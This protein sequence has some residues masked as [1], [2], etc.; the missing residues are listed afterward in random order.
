V[1]AV[2]ASERPRTAATLRRHE[3]PARPRCRR[4]RARTRR[5]RSAPRRRRGWRGKEQERRAQDH[6]AHEA[7]TLE[8]HERE[9]RRQ[10]GDTGGGCFHRRVQARAADPE[11]HL[12]TRHHDAGDQQCEP[13]LDPVSQDIF[14]EEIRLL[15]EQGTAILLSSHQMNLVE[16]LCDQIFLIHQGK[17]VAYDTVENIKERF[18]NYKCELVGLQGEIDFDKDERVERIEQAGNKTIVHLHADVNPLPFVREL[19][20]TMR[21]SELH[22]DRKSLHD[23]FVSI[24]KGGHE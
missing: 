9:Q 2:A 6:V 5:R 22:I 16:Q 1:S 11:G 12:R 21:W 7:L 14:K 10:Q 23:I 8:P 4:R 3:P 17:E 15:A 19:P 13:D 24:A 20:D 18:A